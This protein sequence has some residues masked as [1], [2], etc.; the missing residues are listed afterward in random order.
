MGSR[1]PTA[2]SCAKKPKSRAARDDSSNKSYT[3]G[4]RSGVCLRVTAR[5]DI[6]AEAVVE[7]ASLDHL[8]CCRPEV[9]GSLCAACRTSRGVALCM[10]HLVHLRCPLDEC[11]P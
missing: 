2:Q 4:A 9:L 10:Q 5:T 7:S 1:R 11:R 6:H 3:H 8:S